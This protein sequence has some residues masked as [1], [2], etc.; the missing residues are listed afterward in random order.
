M[1][2]TL[3]CKCIV[4]SQLCQ[5]HLPDSSRCGL[6][7]KQA[8]RA[9]A[10][11]VLAQH[12]VD[13]ALHSALLADLPHKWERLGDLAL[14]PASSL[15]HSAWLQ[16]KGARSDTYGILL[17][18]ICCPA[19]CIVER[20]SQPGS[21]GNWSHP[22]AACRCLPVLKFEEVLAHTVIHHR[23]PTSCADL[24]LPCTSQTLTTP[25]PP[26]VVCMR[27]AARHAAAVGR[28]CSSAGCAAPCKAGT[29]SQ[30]RCELPYFPALSRPTMTLPP[31]YRYT[32][33]SV[34][35]SALASSSPSNASHRTTF[36]QLLAKGQHSIG[37]N[38]DMHKPQPCG[39]LL[40]I[41]RYTRQPRRAAAGR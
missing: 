34:R 39:A 2:T 6:D 28:P 1:L 17:C 24:A 8:M 33:D 27:S 29:R 20:G 32:A 16:G 4:R 23:L 3:P 41:H 21:P 35:Y 37:A 9:A 36:S 15:V 22:P 26:L 30:H 25:Q 14:I 11:S 5:R 7:P 38:T 18:A 10:E 19:L 13:G 40:V 12:A 31:L